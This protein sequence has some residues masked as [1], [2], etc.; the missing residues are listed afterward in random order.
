[1]LN[2]TK[3][4]N[5]FGVVAFRAVCQKKVFAAV[6]NWVVSQKVMLKHF[7]ALECSAKLMKAKYT[8]SACAI[9]LFVRLSLR[10]QQSLYTLHRVHSGEFLPTAREALAFRD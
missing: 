6:C 2:I 7:L 5:I 9:A 1:M 8:P 3:K 4:I 10:A